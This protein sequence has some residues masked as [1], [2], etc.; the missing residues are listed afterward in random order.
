VIDNKVHISWITSSELN[1][2]G[3][4]IQR[5]ILGVD[6]DW[7][8]I[9]FVNG[10]GTTTER[11]SYSFID[12]KPVKGIILY[13]LK[14]IDIDGSFKILPTVSVDYNVPNEFV[15]EQ[16][17]PNPFNPTTKISWQSPVSSWQTLKIY[18]VL[19]NEIATL[20]DEY[21]EA[22]KYEVEFNTVE[23]RHAS[24]LPSGVYFY[25]IKS[26]EYNAL[27]KFILIK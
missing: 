18:D 24:S 27:K 14:Q 8:K 19:G 11:L 3:F 21:R 5:K 6:S 13:R 20:V 26:G 9:G 17:Y 7:E 2:L 4:E 25:Q 10:A 1:N 23:T 15:L 12:N 16:N 22:G